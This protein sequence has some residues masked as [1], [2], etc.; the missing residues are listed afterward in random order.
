MCLFSPGSCALTVMN[1]LCLYTACFDQFYV[2][3]IYYC[4]CV[5][6]YCMDAGAVS[7][8]LVSVFGVIN[9]ES[10]RAKRR[11]GRTAYIHHNIDS[12][13][14]LYNMIVRVYCRVTAPLLNEMQCNSEH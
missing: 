11:S 3:D 13:L 5:W 2:V 12:S 7:F 10:E 6:I 9:P 8:M 4:V 14:F 1:N